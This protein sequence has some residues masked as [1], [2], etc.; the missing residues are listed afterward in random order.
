[1]KGFFLGAPDA[2]MALRCVAALAR[3]PHTRPRFA[4]QKKTEGFGEAK[5]TP[6]PRPWP[7]SA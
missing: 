7:P 2:G 3:K 6:P 5:V 4:P 1:M